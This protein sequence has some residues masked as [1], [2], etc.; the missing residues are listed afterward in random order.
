MEILQLV[1]NRLL[2]LLSQDSKITKSLRKTLFHSS[3]FLSPVA[4]ALAGGKT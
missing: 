1:F 4:L 3:A 2:C